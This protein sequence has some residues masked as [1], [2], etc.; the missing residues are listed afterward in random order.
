M[1][2]IE[3]MME[4]HQ[5]IQRMLKVIQ[6]ICCHITEGGEI[7]S[8]EQYG[9]IDFIRNYADKHHHGKEEKILF[10]V[11]SELNPLAKNV[12]ETGMLVE[13][14][15]G[16]AQVMGWETALKLWQKEPK[17]EFKVDMISYAMGYAHLLQ[18]HTEK[19]NNAVY[20]LAERIIPKDRKSEIDTQVRSFEEEQKQAGIQQKYLNLLEKLEN[21]YIG[22]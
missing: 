15:L 17:T 21:K 12:I 11:M 10:P 1:Y 22:G 8:P 5:H 13:H 7:N 9:I 4:E 3:L 19:E 16:R 14:Q 6:R 20:T 2:S 18:E